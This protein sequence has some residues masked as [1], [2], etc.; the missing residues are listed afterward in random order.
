MTLTAREKLAY[1]V[2]TMIVAHWYNFHD[3][4]YIGTFLRYLKKTN[5]GI[6]EEEARNMNIELKNYMEDLDFELEKE[7]R[8]M[9]EKEKAK[10][11]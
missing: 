4:N 11:R 2:G 5:P 6:S 3:F 8:E 9:I 10:H 7:M 1:A